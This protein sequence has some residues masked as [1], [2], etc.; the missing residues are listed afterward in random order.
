MVGREGRH[1]D[2]LFGVSTGRE[3]MIHGEGRRW[4]GSMEKDEKCGV[5]EAGTVV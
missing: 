5:K 3:G 1:R 4:E 2:G